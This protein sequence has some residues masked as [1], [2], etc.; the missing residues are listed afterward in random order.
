MST[1]SYQDLNVPLQN[2][3]KSLPHIMKANVFDPSELVTAIEHQSQLPSRD[4]NDVRILEVISW[5]EW[6]ALWQSA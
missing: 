4:S 1:P 2:W 5:V 6:T 3:L